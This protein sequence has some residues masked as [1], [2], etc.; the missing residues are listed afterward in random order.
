[1]PDA[2]IPLCRQA[3]A[4]PLFKSSPAAILPLYLG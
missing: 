1:M 3:P 2:F 4:G